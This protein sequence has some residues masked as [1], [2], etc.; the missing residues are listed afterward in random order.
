MRSGAHRLSGYD[1]ALGRSAET[2][3]IQGDNTREVRTILCVR[4]EAVDHKF[5]SFCFSSLFKIREHG[6]QSR[7]I[8]KM[9]KKKPICTDG[10]TSFQSVR[11]IDCSMLVQFLGTGLAAAITVFAVEMLWHHRAKYMRGK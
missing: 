1:G 6:I 10:G 11:F 8:A 3:P 5:E 7:E 4:N 2:I 9:Y